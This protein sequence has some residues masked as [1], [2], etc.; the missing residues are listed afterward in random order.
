MTADQTWVDLAP[1][2]D[3]IRAWLKDATDQVVTFARPP[4]GDAPPFSVLQLISDPRIILTID[5]GQPAE[6][7][8]QVDA[9]GT[10]PLQALGLADKVARAM[11]TAAVPTL[12]GATVDIRE[13]LGDMHGPNKVGESGEKWV[14][15]ARYRWRLIGAATV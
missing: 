8:W 5:G 11:V 3:P 9:F 10:T 13:A 2:V 14:V 7:V 6:V 15:Q 1:T 12:P 4:K